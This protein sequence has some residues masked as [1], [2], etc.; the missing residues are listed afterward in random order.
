MTQATAAA[1][2]AFAHDHALLLLPPSVTA[3]DLHAVGVEGGI[4]C[5][6]QTNDTLVTVLEE[7]GLAVVTIERDLGRPDNE[8]YV[9]ADNRSTTRE[10]LE[11]MAD[12]GAKRI[13]FLTVDLPIAWAAECLD[14][15]EAWCAETDR[16]PLVVPT[17]P[18]VPGADA[19]SRTS[20]LLDGPNPP[21]AILASDERYPSSVIRAADERGIRIPAEL[22]LATGIDSHEA[23]EA[24]PAVTAI[25]IQPAIQGAAAAEL[26][27]GRLRGD[28]VER[29]RT[30]P[31]RLHVRAS[32]TRET[33]T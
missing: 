20:E 18:H 22:M 16:E 12:R 14:A 10:L 7:L 32:T 33:A 30:T 23:R 31:A 25:D 3:P 8:W 21:D 24:S 2:T 4:V 28:P 27:V 11:H 1:Q 13:G 5:D 26:L 9:C 29:P 17:N 15:Y 6:P 19:Y